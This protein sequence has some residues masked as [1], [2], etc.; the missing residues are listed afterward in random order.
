MRSRTDV[1]GLRRFLAILQADLRERTRTPR[2]WALLTAVVVATWWCFPGP[3]DGYM[4]LSVGRG[5]RGSYSSAWVG[6]VLA[7]AYSM[8]LGL[9]GFYLVRGTLVRDI[10]TRVWQLLV[11]TP[12]TRAGFLLAKWASHMAILVLIVAVGLC[13]GLIAQWL[14]AEDRHFDVIEAAKPILLLSLPGLAITSAAA[15]WFDLVPWL[16]RTAGNV[17]Y[18]IGWI[19]VLSVSV[20]QLEIEHSSARSTWLSDPS[21]LLVAA[22][23]FQR[24]R[25]EQTGVDQDFGFSLGQPRPASGPTI[26]A[27]PSWSVRP[28]D[29]AGRVLWL[30]LAF[31]SLLIAAPL[32]DRAAARAS[33]SARQRTRAGRRLRWLDHA[34]HLFERGPTGILAVAELKLVLR[35]RRSWWWFAVLVAWGL[36]AFGSGD[37]G[38]FGLLLAWALPLDILSRS[39]LRE[40]EHRTGAL[41]FNAP[42]ALGRLLVVRLM[43][44][45]ALVLALTVP[46][47]LRMLAIAPTS[48][49]AIL[50]VGASI[51]SWGLCLGA[52]TLSSRPFELLLVLVLYLGMQGA[53]ILD[54]AGHA[55]LVIRWHAFALL[56][57]WLLLAWAWPKLARR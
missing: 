29:I 20:A 25:T 40:S 26:F 46:G 50:V 52:L 4:I 22:R 8:L 3:D 41:V 54:V 12:M 30:G 55:P 17:L 44:G 33:T 42:R 53:P 16:R 35:E 43:V 49:L 11:A 32:L 48:V 5:T 13:V 6:M 18:F 47:M 24:V 7:M 10:E 51:V 28:M 15:I 37:A 14:R 23:D 27:W 19:T 56:P 36:Q 21:G 1:D 31:A 34:L 38:R 45:L 57:A 39:V 2:F 9:G